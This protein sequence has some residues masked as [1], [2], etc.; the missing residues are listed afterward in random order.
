MP[1]KPKRPRDPNHLVKLIT[2]IATGEV[3]EVET[4]DGKDPAALLWGAKVASRGGKARFNALTPERRKE[5][6]GSGQNK[7]EETK[8]RPRRVFYYR[9]HESMKLCFNDFIDW[10]G[11]HETRNQKRTSWDAG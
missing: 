3:E 11:S 10:R 1:T 7:M 8:T 6:A 5:I 2:G 9:L 4:D